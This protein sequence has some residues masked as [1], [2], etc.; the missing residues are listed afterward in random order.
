[1][2]GMRKRWML[3]LRNCHENHN[4]IHSNETIDHA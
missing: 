1:M 3:G 4:S 2:R